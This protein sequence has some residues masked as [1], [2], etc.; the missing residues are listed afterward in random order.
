MNIQQINY[1][2]AVS[3]LKSFGKAADRCFIG[4]STLSTMISRY[5]QEIGVHIFDRKTKPITVTKEGKSIIAQLKSI[6]REI[7]T[8]DQVVQ[9]LKGE[10]S[11]EVR[12]GVIP[13]VAPFLLPRFL[14]DFAEKY[15]NL[16]FVITERNTAAIEEALLKREMDIGILAIP[17]EKPD[18]LEVPLYNEEFVLYDCQSEQSTRV[19]QLDEINYD[20]FWLLEEGHCLRTQIEKIC[21]FEN[22]YTRKSINFNYNA[23]SIDSLLRFV[24]MNQGVT[25]LPY[26]AT[27][28]M[29]AKDKSKISHFKG[30]IPVRTIGL[31]VHKHFVKKKILELLRED[32]QAKIL[33]L[34]NVDSEG[35]I[36]YKPL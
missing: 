18:F 30:S 20:K 3:E 35:E 32:I 1:I 22:C 6:S 36:V 9:V 29:P 5:E 23:G 33:P 15:P 7:D 24:K 4:Q 31:V 27:L 2:I 26:L 28:D 12:I 19:A 25:L 14:N 10:L 34:L 13:T 16:S 11:G 17:L 8:L 21:D